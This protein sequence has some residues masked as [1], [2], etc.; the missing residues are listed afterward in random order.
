LLQRRPGPRTAGT[1][2]SQLAGLDG[3]WIVSHVLGD[4]RGLGVAAIARMK[5]RSVMTPTI[6]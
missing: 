6:A 5:S 4:L 1:I 2:G 3:P